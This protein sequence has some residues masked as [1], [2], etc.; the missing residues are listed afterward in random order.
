METCK[1][2][3]VWVNND[4]V[5]FHMIIPCAPSRTID[6]ALAFPLLV[7]ML[8]AQ[9]GDTFSGYIKK[10]KNEHGQ[11]CTVYNLGKSSRCSTFKYSYIYVSHEC[12]SWPHGFSQRNDETRKQGPRAIL[13]IRKKKNKKK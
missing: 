6:K 4:L 13:F 10:D 7:Q 9:A 1:K 8:Q 3:Q 2:F 5:I 11:R 12:A